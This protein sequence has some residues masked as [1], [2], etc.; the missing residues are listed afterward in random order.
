MNLQNYYQ[1]LKD[2]E[3]SLEDEHIVVVSL[4][5]PDGGKAGVRTEVTRS[6]A[7]KLI[8][9]G[10]AVAASAEVAESFRRELRDAKIRAEQ[11]LL[12][13]RMQVTVITD[14]ELKQLRERARLKG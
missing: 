4:A 13:E 12:T 5:T 3:S 6:V 1:K 2:I 9:E 8:A 10:R 11:A 7:A 14:A